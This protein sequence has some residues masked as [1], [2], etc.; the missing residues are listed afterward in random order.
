MPD[1][2]L[3]LLAGILAAVPL[4]LAVLAISALVLLTAG[5]FKNVLVGV[6]SL[7]LLF[8]V[9]TAKVR[10]L[11]FEL[12]IYVYPQ[13]MLFIPMAGVA[14]VRWI[15]FGA[16]AR[17]PKSLGILTGIMSLSFVWGLNNYGTSAGV[18]FRNEFYFLA[19][20]FYFASFS[21]TK[22][23][24]TR[25]L[26]WLLPST[27]LLLVVVWY[28]WTA[29]AVGLDWFEPI[30][31]D[32]DE[33]GVAMRVI[34]AQQTWL[35][36]LVFIV[37]A[38]SAIGRHSLTRWSLALPLIFITV[39]GLQHRSVW[40]ATVLPVALALFIVKRNRGKSAS[41]MLAIGV[42][43]T[44][45]L[46]PLLATERFSAVTSSV[47]EQAIR[48]TST[49]EG[50]FVARVQ[51]WDALLRQWINGGPIAWAIGNPYGSGYWRQVGPR[52]EEVVWSPHN[53]YVQLLLRTGSLG[54][55]AFLFFNLYLFRGTWRLGSGPNN[56]FNGYSMLGA[57]ISFA[58]FNI[59]YSPTY[60]QGLLL[61]V[62]L[63]VV[64]HYQAA[65]PKSS[66]STRAVHVRTRGAMT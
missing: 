63:S 18:E 48:A 39:I 53:Y 37:L 58:L 49:E 44:L 60:T 43:L 17:L 9:E 57:L 23:R 26:G 34:N 52:G 27:M 56:K 1:F 22:K 64:M 8:L 61:G 42:A 29:D 4:I 55:L 32:A 15:R 51:S 20:L 24:I 45:V 21:W 5:L 38:Y 16:P 62:I 59:P 2:L 31:R 66:E 50:T 65:I 54:M 30:W 33:T 36:G 10:L 14:L 13:D 19:S 28:R 12:G 11:G 25:L 35:L 47:S 46:L 3:A 6:V 7:L 40:V 41:R